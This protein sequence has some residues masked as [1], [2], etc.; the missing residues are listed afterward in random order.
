MFD[1]G[2]DAWYLHGVCAVSFR[3]PVS[4]CTSATP[5]IFLDWM[6]LRSSNLANGS[7]T[8][9]FTPCAALSV[10]MLEFI[11]MMRYSGTA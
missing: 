8:A 5:S 10:I 3:R 9:G 1:L 2:N 7:S 4:V 6:K 11:R